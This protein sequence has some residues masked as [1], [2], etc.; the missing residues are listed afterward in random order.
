MKDFFAQ[1]V[2][3]YQYSLQEAL[4]PAEREHLEYY[5][6]LVQMLLGVNP[7][8]LLTGGIGA[9]ASWVIS[10]GAGITNCAVRSLLGYFD[11]EGIPAEKERLAVRAVISDIIAGLITP[12][13]VGDIET[14]FFTLRSIAA[15]GGITLHGV[16]TDLDNMT[17]RQMPV[18]AV[19]EEAFQNHV[20]LVTSVT[21]E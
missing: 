8:I 11:G 9:I 5:M 19:I 12:V 6:P 7:M 10:Q 17:G 14:S 18:I 3:A 16:E 15:A 1:V 2:Q 4:S 21:G 20:V 13:T